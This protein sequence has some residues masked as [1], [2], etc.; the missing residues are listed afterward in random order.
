MEPDF[1][2]LKPEHDGAS[3]PWPCASDHNR[4]IR[5]FDDDVLTKQPDGNGF[6]K[7]TGLCCLNIQVDET[8]LDAYEG[9]PA[10]TLDGVTPYFTPKPVKKVIRD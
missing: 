3:Y 8:H 6:T 2:K 4:I 7:H 5:L 9:W 1:Y 10:M